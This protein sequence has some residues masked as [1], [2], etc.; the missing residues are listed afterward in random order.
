MLEIKCPYC[1][2]G[3]DVWIAAIEDSGFCLKM[4][5]GQLCLDRTHS[6][7]YQVQCQLFVCDVEYGDFCVCTF[8][9]NEDESH[10]LE[11]GMHIERI[12]KDLIFGLSAPQ[13]QV[14]FS[15]HVY[16]Q[17]LWETDTLGLVSLLKPATPV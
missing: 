17:R 4:V 11:T 2:R 5:D 13:N 15:R 14:S 12:Y 7:Y 16:Y 8:S 3:T 6:Y 1:H 10:H 9:M